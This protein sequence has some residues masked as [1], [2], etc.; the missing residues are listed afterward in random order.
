MTTS[1][2]PAVFSG[3]LSKLT[4]GEALTTGILNHTLQG[5]E[6]ATPVCIPAEAMPLLGPLIEGPVAFT[7]QIVGGFLHVSGPAE[8]YLLC[9]E[10]T[11]INEHV[12]E[13]TGKTVLKGEI[14]LE[15]EEVDRDFIIRDP[16]WIEVIA[17][18]FEPYGVNPV[19]FIAVMRGDLFEVTDVPHDEEIQAIRD[20]MADTAEADHLAATSDAPEAAPSDPKRASDPIQAIWDTATPSTIH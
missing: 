1:C 13:I 4:V 11:D 8:R 12:C 20:T 5:Q 10:I 2:T 19:N 15:N 18:S 9:G 17:E 14:R 6:H 7:G 16:E 3:T